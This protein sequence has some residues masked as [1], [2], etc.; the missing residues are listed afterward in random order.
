MWKF[1][2]LDTNKD[3][4]LRFKE[5]RPFGRFVRK[6][7]KPRPCAKRF[8]KFCD[9]N[10]DRIIEEAEWTLCLGV[11][12]KRKFTYLDQQDEFKSIFVC[13]ALPR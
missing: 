3:N 2:G 4:Q 7:I 6:L 13:Y 1:N 11:D 9:K 12:I 8:L 5:I 10:R